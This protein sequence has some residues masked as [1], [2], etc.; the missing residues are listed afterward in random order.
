MEM[1]CFAHRGVSSKAPENTMA[2]FAL[3]VVHHVHGIELDVHLSADGKLV[4]IHD[5]STLRTTGVDM[6]VGQCEYA[7][8]KQ[9]DAGSWFGSKFAG[10]RV[11][12]LQDVLDL[13]KGEDIILNVELKN[14]YIDYPG[15]EAQ[16]LRAVDDFGLGEQVMVSS[17]NH[18]SLARLH[19]LRPK[20]ECAPLYDARLAGV[21]QYAQLCGSRALHPHWQALDKAVVEEAQAAGLTVRPWTVNSAC[22]AQAMMDMGMYELITNY[23]YDLMEQA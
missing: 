17:F 9:L 12:L 7:K 13:I 15:L 1:K 22:V 19:A 8:L 14:A 20:M 2:A 16:M 6:Q 23:P 4:V 5:E 10:E 3:A 18:I 21:G 11:P